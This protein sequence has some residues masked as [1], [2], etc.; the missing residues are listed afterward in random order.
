MKKGAIVDI[1][2]EGEPTFRACV[3]DEA[4]GYDTMFWVVDLRD[5]ERTIRDLSEMSDPIIVDIFDID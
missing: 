4:S 5:G 3:F 2:A 1:H